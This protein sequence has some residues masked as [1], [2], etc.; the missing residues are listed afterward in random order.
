M[1]QIGLILRFSQLI[2][3]SDQAMPG[4]ERWLLGGHTSTLANEYKEGGN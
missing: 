3:V 1:S 4:I 2:A